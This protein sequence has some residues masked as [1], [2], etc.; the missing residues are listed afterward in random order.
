MKRTARITGFTLLVGVFIIVSLLISQFA[1]AFIDLRPI[2]VMPAMGMIPTIEITPQLMNALVFVESSN[3]PFAF[4]RFTKARGLT[5]ITPIAWK[6][7]KRHYR[8]KYAGLTYRKDIYNPEIAR[9]AGR[10]YLYILQKY[11]Q[12]KGIPVTLD[13]LLASYVWGIGNLSRYGLQKAPRV[14]KNYIS[15]IKKHAALT[16]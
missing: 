16:S 2:P 1:F 6:E 13:N 14:V 3:N 9:E 4:N 8:A 11:L 5:Q 12:A 15:S 7:L 10:D